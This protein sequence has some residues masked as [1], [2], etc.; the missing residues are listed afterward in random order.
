MSSFIYLLKFIQLKLPFN[1]TKFYKHSKGITNLTLIYKRS[2]IYNTLH[3]KYINIHFLILT[4]VNKA[5]IYGFKK[6][7]R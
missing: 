4:K 3:P 1:V 2:N 7:R 5:N 6:R